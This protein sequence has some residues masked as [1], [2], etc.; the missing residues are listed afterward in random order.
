MSRAAA[1]TPMTISVTRSAPAPPS[2]WIS[3]AASVI[4]P[5]QSPSP[6]SG[7]IT[8]SMAASCPSLNGPEESAEMY[9]LR[10]S[11]AIARRY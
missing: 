6:A 4:A 3:S 11:T 10:P 8:S 7:A 5:T 1:T 9:R 2:P